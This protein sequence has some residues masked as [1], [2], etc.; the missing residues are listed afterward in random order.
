MS[1][2][3]VADNGDICQSR[4]VKDKR[5]LSN[6]KVMIKN[7]SDS[8][9]TGHGKEKFKLNIL[10]HKQSKVIDNSN[11]NCIATVLGQKKSKV[12]DTGKSKYEVTILGQ[13]E[14]KVIDTCKSKCEVT[15]LGQK[16]SKVI[17]TCKSKCE[18]TILGQKES[19]VIDTCKSKCEVTILGQKESKV[20]D[21]CKSKCEVTILGQKES[22]EKD[23]SKCKVTVLGQQ[24]GKVTV[25]RNN[26]VTG[27]VTNL[28]STSSL[29]RCFKTLDLSIG[30][31]YMPDDYTTDHSGR[32]ITCRHVMP[33]HPPGVETGGQQFDQSVPFDLV[34]EALSLADRSEC[35]YVDYT[36][37]TFVPSPSVCS[38][39]VHP[40]DITGP[41]FMYST[42]RPL[43]PFKSYRQQQQQQHQPPPPPQQK[44]PRQKP[45]PQHHRREV[46]HK[47]KKHL[48]PTIKP[49]T[50]GESTIDANTY[51]PPR[52]P[53]VSDNVTRDLG[54]NEWSDEY[55]QQMMYRAYL[56][57]NQP[58]S[59]DEFKKFNYD[60]EA[61]KNKNNNRS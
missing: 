36:T 20:I 13:K 61:N 27:K 30:R 41:K 10:G 11:E 40:S 25:N 57:N 34:N 22:K 31:E 58:F 23:N 14:S 53:P 16:E 4:E 24:E 45:S 35:R 33:I 54:L 52:V 32:F 12:I 3:P 56:N 59:F 39:Y 19:K 26:K 1:N 60:I 50:D 18:V 15:I 37:T 8:K 47:P 21:T 9:V 42:Y 17:D 46:Q 29:H 55:Q 49:M 28:E 51:L 44:Q 2:L 5:P 43:S 6:I 48:S 7:K 38:D